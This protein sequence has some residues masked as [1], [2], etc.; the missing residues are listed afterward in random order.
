MKYALSFSD[1]TLILINESTPLLIKIAEQWILTNN[2]SYKYCKS[3][4]V[5]KYTDSYLESS[6][7][8]TGA[9]SLSS[10]V[11]EYKKSSSITQW[12]DIAALQ[13]ADDLVFNCELHDR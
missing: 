13:T 2:H 12:C 4:S 10:C 11:Q 6:V 5:N 7:R 9:L 8:N 3:L 1:N